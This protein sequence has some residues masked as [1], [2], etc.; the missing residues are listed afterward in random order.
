MRKTGILMISLWASIFGIY[1]QNIRGTLVDELQ[2]PVAY[3]NVILQGADSSYLAGTTTD[4]EG[5]FSL[6]SREGARL[7]SIS[8]IGYQ[9]VCRE[10]TGY[11][12]WRVVQM[13]PDAQVLGEVVD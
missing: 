13:Q 10:I 1:A 5:A 6:P 4:L 12:T 3:A 2:Q 7:I 11:A 9:T 8:F